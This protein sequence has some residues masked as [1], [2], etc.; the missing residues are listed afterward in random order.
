MLSCYTDGDW[1]GEQPGGGLLKFAPSCLP[2]PWAM[3]PILVQHSRMDR[4]RMGLRPVRPEG[5]RTARRSGAQSLRQ[6][7]LLCHR[8]LFLGEKPFASEVSEFAKLFGHERLRLSDLIGA[9]P[10]A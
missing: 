7:A 8:E 10:S 6:K 9:A 2:L 3:L 4:V 1:I 5:S